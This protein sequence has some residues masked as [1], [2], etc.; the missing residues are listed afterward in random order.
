MLR[1]YFEGFFA[2]LGL[3]TALPV[4]GRWSDETAGLLLPSLPL[5]GLLLGG[6]W[7]GLAALLALWA[8]GSV[9]LK[10]ALLALTLPAL[11]G[12]LH[13]DGFADTADAVFS[14][15][16]KEEKRRILKD[17]HIGAFGVIQLIVWFL[18]A[19]A[20]CVTIAQTGKAPLTL[21]FLPVLSR[22]LGAFLVLGA[23]LMADEG[24]AAYYRKYTR[25][26]HFVFLGVCTAACLV[27]AF[28]F[29]GARTLL[30]LGVLAAG[31]L[32]CALYTC[33][34]L[35]GINGDLAGCAITVGELCGLL[36]LAALC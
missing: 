26:A 7:Y 1:R 20:S 35:G 36:A 18:F 31:E 30:A 11:T 13:M 34:Q 25:P 15:R 27:C 6:I 9:W 19:F 29:G 5:A 23:P 22:C 21:L 24:Y 2:S 3:F 12:F 16:D 14:R 28:L 10:G 17:S 8:G 4:K 33:R 32:L